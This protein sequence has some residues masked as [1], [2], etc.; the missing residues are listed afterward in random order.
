MSTVNGING[1][2]RLFRN[3]QASSTGSC[4]MTRPWSDAAS[5]QSSSLRRPQHPVAC[6]SGS[7]AGW[8]SPSPAGSG[9]TLFRTRSGLVPGDS[10]AR[11]TP[12][13]SKTPSSIRLRKLI[14]RNPRRNPPFSQETFPD[15]LSENC[16]CLRWRRILRGRT[17]AIAFYGCRRRSW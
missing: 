14:D 2:D 10:A 16:F 11:Q 6:T 13:I 8:G 12:A 9:K 1:C 7:S 5:P 17:V 4:K 3:P 15:P